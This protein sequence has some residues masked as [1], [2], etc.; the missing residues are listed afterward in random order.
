MSV[1]Q[2]V[3]N[4]KEYDAFCKFIEDNFLSVAYKQLK[5]EDDVQ[6]LFRKQGE[7]KAYENMLT[8]RDIVNG[9]K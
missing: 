3:N 5:Q 8:L 4:K 9:D 7:I 6:R 2:F 1:K